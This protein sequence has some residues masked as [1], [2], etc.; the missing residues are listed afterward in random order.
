M[1]FEDAVRGG[2]CASCLVVDRDFFCGSRAVLDFDSGAGFDDI[3]LMMMSN[4]GLLIISW[5]WNIRFLNIY[6]EGVSYTDVM[7]LVSL[8][9]SRE[10]TKQKLTYYSLYVIFK[11]SILFIL[12]LYLASFD[13][14]SGT[15]KIS[16]TNS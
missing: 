3:L 11:R 7:D 12:P 13:A 1:S 10:G 2:F 8:R 15:R 5:R 6:L 4:F 14:Q 16:L 9:Q